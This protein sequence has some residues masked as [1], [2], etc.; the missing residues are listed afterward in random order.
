MATLNS[1]RKKTSCT[2]QKKRCRM[3][4]VGLPPCLPQ[5]AQSFEQLLG[6]LGNLSAES[7]L[8]ETVLNTL[9]HLFPHGPTDLLA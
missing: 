3:S 8:A 6:P 5:E 1:C 7:E 9:S 2:I 4:S